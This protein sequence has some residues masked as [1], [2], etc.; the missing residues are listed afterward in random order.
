[1]QVRYFCAVV[2]MLSFSTASLIRSSTYAASNEP[3]IMSISSN[4]GLFSGSRSPASQS[5]GADLQ[6]ELDRFLGS[7]KPAAKRDWEVKPD[8]QIVF[9]KSVWNSTTDAEGSEVFTLKKSDSEQKRTVIRNEDKTIRTISEYR[10]D[11]KKE[12]YWFVF[13]LDQKLA[14]ATTCNDKTKDGLRNCVTAIPSV[15]K[16]LPKNRATSWTLPKAVIP[17]VDLVEKR[18]LATVLS[19][20]GESHQ[21]ENMAKTGNLIGLKHKLQTTRGRL[22]SSP[23]KTEYIKET[24]ELC[25]RA[26]FE[27]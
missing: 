4:A 3:P 6:A 26:H 8:G 23:V 25:A 24:S 17:D 14:A 10:L 15:C 5:L 18:A 13:F 12:N 2:A 9:D 20:R 27:F 11:S 22:T 21:M 1:M 19:M 16:S 7:R